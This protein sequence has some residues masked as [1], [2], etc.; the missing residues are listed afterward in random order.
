VRATLL[1]SIGSVLRDALGRKGGVQKVLHLLHIELGSLRIIGSR[2]R[3]GQAGL[4]HELVPVISL[5][6]E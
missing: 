2:N 6:F 4:A 5:Q 1:F 3:I